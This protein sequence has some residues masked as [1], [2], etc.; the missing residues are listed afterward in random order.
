MGAEVTV[1]S[2]TVT[3][4]PPGVRGGLF[5]QDS[6]GIVIRN[7][8]FL[9]LQSSPNTSAARN[10]QTPVTAVGCRFENCTGGLLSQ[11]SVTIVQDCEFVGCTRTALGVSSAPLLEVRNSYFADNVSTSTSPG[12]IGIGLSVFP[13]IADC[14]FINNRS[15]GAGGAISA[16]GATTLERNVFFGNQVVGT[17]AGGAADLFGTRLT[18]RDN[19]FY[20]SAAPSLFGGSTLRLGSDQP[21]T[22][23][24][25]VIAGS[26]GGVAVRVVEGQPLSNGCNVYWNNPDGN[27]IG[28]AM[29][30]TDREEDPLFCDPDNGDLTLESL[31]PCLPSNSLGC[32]LI[33]ALGQGCG[34]VSVEP[35]SWGQIKGAYR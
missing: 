13:V 29:D 9:D 18:I 7:C 12:A 11:S 26:T 17:G 25:N 8:E 34:T 31:S 33:G 23:E 15:G 6:Q 4:S 16:Y 22:L 20:G 2:L 32:G 21:F 30:E 14:V 3:G 5:I 1:E 24:N 19:T 27:V 35:M 28:F 10:L